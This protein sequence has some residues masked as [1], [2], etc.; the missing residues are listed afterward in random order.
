VQALM[1]LGYSKSEAQDA[2]N[3]TLKSSS[4]KMPVDK[5]VRSALKYV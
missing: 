3:K 5:L 4:E 2:V 1:A